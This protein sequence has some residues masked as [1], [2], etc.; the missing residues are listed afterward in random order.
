M[1]IKTPLAVAITLT[2]A[3]GAAAPLQAAGQQAVAATGAVA[4]DAVDLDRIEV[5]AQL[6]S[7]I[8]AVD[9]KRSSNAIEDAVSSDAL[10]QYPDKNV[11]ES[12]QRLPGISVTRDQGEG[13][14]VV[15]RG[16]DANLNSVSVDGIAIGTPD[17]SSRAAPMDVIPSDSTERLRVV[18]SPTPDM[19]GD[20]IGGAILVETASAFDREGRSLRGK[21]EGSHQQ[22]S[23]ETSPKA[24][25]N[26]SEVFNDTFGIAA[27]VNYQKRTFESDNSEVEY[28]DVSGNKDPTTTRPGEIT[29]LNLQNRKYEIERKRI[30]A[31][32]NFDWRPN[33]DSR[34]Y[35]RTLYS[36]FDDAETRQRVIF[37]FNSADMIATGTD[38]YRLAGMPKDSIDKRMR[39]RTKEENTFA[40]SLGGENKLTDA[41][42]DYKIGYTRTEERVDD[43]I[44]SRFKLNGKAF[45]GTLDQRSRLP[46]YTFDNDQWLDNANYKFDRVVAKPKK[47]D[48]EE[49]SAQVNIRFDGDNSSYKFG[50][51]GRWRDRDVNVD[52]ASLRV[53]PAIKLSDWTTGSPEHRHGP[54][55][56]GM[57]SSAMRSYWSQHG[58]EYSARPQDVGGNAATSLEGDYTAREDVFASYAMGTWDIGA[59]RVIGGVRVENTRF[60]ATGNRVDVA[61]DGRSYT[62]TRVTAS[63]SYNNVLP[64]LHL[65]YDAGDDWVFRFAANKTV[66]RPGFGDASPR[67]GLAR[68]DNEV[69]LGNPELDPYESTNID[70][71]VE[72]YIG[73]SGILS[74]GVFH[75]SIDG[76]IVQV[77]QAGADGIYD[78]LPVVTS[79]NGDK[80]KVRGAEFNWQQQLSFLPAGWDGL[81]VGAS[82]T[83]LDTDFDPGLAKRAGEDFTLPRA[84][85]N[86]YS[87]HIGYEKYGLSTRV[88]AVH[89]SEYLDTLGAGRAFD[90]YV[91]PNTQLDFSLD[92]RFTPRVSMYFEAQN[93]LDKPLELYQ[94][95]RSR[96]L[97]M[98][99]YGRTYALG[100]KVA[101]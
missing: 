16:L 67:I 91:A 70:L 51:L 2:L 98:E 15:V 84:S 26:Y 80:A 4:A 18:K 39:Y 3:M 27:G 59:L 61:K 86:V 24:A 79:V 77:R 22:L 45:N 49:R 85:K 97:Q 9:L 19:P 31:N 87:A 40:A 28:G 68:N 58:G 12:L 60:S 81:L 78:G 90:I 95:T 71:S 74:L 75:K 35:L 52:E 21:I 99:E 94:G 5:R 14:Y 65:R 46:T 32:L 48:D 72:K 53:G 42:L 83:W 7:Q 20:A 69:R 30:G 76:Y 92:Y 62:A 36:Q 93:L 29:A 57:D 88:A 56:Q 8:R 89:R 44:E 1:H 25:F 41:V 43:E 37:N 34:Y 50:L 17:N 96:T 11:A 47:V 101:L 23:G 10:G 66:A 38:Q 13:R 54:M 64:G 73:E 63:K 55:G 100:L 6:E 33:E 82:G